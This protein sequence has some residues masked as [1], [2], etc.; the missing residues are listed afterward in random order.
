MP[1]RFLNKNYFTNLQKNIYL[2]YWSI[3]MYI[4]NLDTNNIIVSKIK[5]KQMCNNNF[6]LKID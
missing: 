5:A 1:S 3:F 6:E 2:T 4:C